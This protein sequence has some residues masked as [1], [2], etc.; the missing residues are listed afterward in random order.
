[1][2]KRETSTPGHP[3]DIKI[4]I[5]RGLGLSREDTAASCGVSVPT[6]D[7]RKNEPT[8][9]EWEEWASG[10]LAVPSMSA[11]R[12]LEAQARKRVGKAMLAIDKA[13]DSD[14]PDVALRGA[15]RA[16]DRA[17]GK[18]TQRVETTSDVTERV[19]YEIPEAA[20]AA[21]TQFAAVVGPK[22]IAATADVIDVTAENEEQG[23]TD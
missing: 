17:V 8:T 21:L 10:L 9:K 14:D 6:V 3:T 23:E 5:C 18:A 11:E 13:L 22:R 15:D 2:R 12:H 7:L 1:M 16:L 20:L 19:I 4:G